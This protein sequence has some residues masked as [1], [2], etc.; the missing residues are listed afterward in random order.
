ML[1]S[2][3]H[4]WRLTRMAA[5]LL[6]Y[7]VLLPQEYQNRNPLWLQGVAR[8]LRLFSRPRRGQTPG[9]RLATALERLGPAYV[10]FGQ[11]LATRPDIIGVTASQTSL[12]SSTRKSRSICTG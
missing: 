9:E 12:G 7:D 4:T 2:V 1:D 10:K 11:F 5:T 8:F 6:R 3:G